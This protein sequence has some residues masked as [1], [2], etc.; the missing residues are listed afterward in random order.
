MEKKH[1]EE[2]LNRAAPIHPIT[3]DIDASPEIDKISKELISEDEVK[4]SIRFLKNRYDF[5]KIVAELLKADL[6][7]SNRELH[8]I[9]QLI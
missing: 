8:E 1:F 5:D 4:K 3:I 6:E 9:I 2:I 7:T